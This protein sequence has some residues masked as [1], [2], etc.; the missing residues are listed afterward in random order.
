MKHF[1]AAISLTCLTI[2]S[3]LAQKSGNSIPLFFFRNPGL[4][5]S[6]ISFIVE[7]PQLRA[8]FRKDSVVFQL[9][10][11]NAAVRFFGAN[12]NVRIEAAEPQTGNVNF[13]IGD[14]SQWSAG[15]ATYRKITY[16]DLY[17]GI[18]M[19]YSG[20]RARVKS[21]FVVAPGADPSRIR[22]SY[23]AEHVSID[24]NGDLTLS[25]NTGELREAAP[26]I[27]QEI[28]GRRIYVDGR[29]LLLDAHTVG[30][31]I[32]A[33][34]RTKTLVIDPTLSYSTYLG[35]T[36]S[37]AVT[38]VAVDT[39]ANLYVTGW[40]AALN[41]PIAGSVQS[42][43]Q[44]GVD[45]F[46]VKLNPS[47]TSILYA[48]YI[49][50]NGDDRAAAI[51]VDAA[52]EA[53]VTGSTASTN[54][55]KVSSLR[56]TLGGGRDAYVLKLN[57]TGN[58]L[59][60]STLLGGMSN[61][62][63][64]AIAVDSS[65]NAYIAGDTLSTDFPINGPLQPSNGGLQDAFVTKLSSTGAMVFSTYLGG[66]QNEHAGGIAVDA[67]G[68][69]YV[70]GGTFSTNFPTKSPL[71]SANG[72]GQDAFVTKIAA[73][74]ASLVYSSYLGGT[75]GSVS[76]PEQANGIAIDSSGNAYVGGVTNSINFPVTSGA[77]QTAFRGGQD[78]FVTKINSAGSA[79]VYSTF[80]GGSS[81]DQVNGIA[82]DA[83]GNAYAAG[84]TSSQDF[85]TGSGVQAT[86]NGL[87]DAF[88]SELN[89]AGNGLAFSTY[90]GGTG[91]DEA[92]TIALDSLANIFV[93]GQTGS[94]DMTMKTPIQA[95]NTGGSTGW[96]ARI[97]VTSAPPQVPAVGTV[98]PSSGN[99]NTITFTATYSHPAGA[100][101]LTNVAFLVNTN[102]ST[103]YGCYIS[104]SPS[105]NQFM[106]YNDVAT[107][108]GTTV[109]PGG[110]TA[111]N[112]YCSLIGTGS[113]AT[114]SGTT[115]TITLSV[116]FQN[117][118]AGAKTIYLYAQDANTNTGWV[119]KG[120]Y[121]ATVAIAQPSNVSVS[122]NSNA[123]TTQTFQ[124]VWA[125]SQNPANL[126]ATAI[127][128]GASSSTLTNSCF[129]VYDSL[130]ATVQL[131]YDNLAGSNTKSISSSTPISNSQCSI[132]SASVQNSGLSIVLSLTISF[133]ATF[134]GQKN[135]FMY[136]SDAS[137][138][139]TG[140]QQMGTFTIAT[141]GYPTAD[142]VVPSSGTGP[143]Q[144]FTI[145]VSDVGGSAYINDI[146]V[147]IS[148]S[149]A[150]TN[151]ACF[152]LFDRV[153]NTLSVYYDNPGS[154]VT[155]LPLGSTGTASNSQCR[156]N[157]ANSTVIYGSTSVA[158]T[159]D[160]T[161]TSSF[162]G[163][164]NVYVYGAEASTNTGWAQRGTWTV[165]GGVPTAISVSPSAGTGSSLTNFVFA[166]SDSSS[167]S[168]L[169]G[170]SILVTSGA[171][172]NTANACYVVMNVT[173]GTVG[174][175]A[176]NGTT[177]NTKPFG[178]SANLLNSQ[179][180]I[181]GASVNVPSPGTTATFTVPILFYPAKFAGAK[182]VYLSANEPAATSGFVSVGS[183]TVQ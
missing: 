105:L 134:N 99:G 177:L 91:S 98:T 179:C 164:K 170:A 87:Y 44:G 144:R 77:F 65:G 140:W 34:D 157:A 1:L 54:F 2:G 83:S 175:Y 73:G 67:T 95:T 12:P 176:D 150:N 90:F 120:T 9:P 88:V 97:G 122:P 152:V 36:S 142:Y 22:L 121:T 48:T 15:N 37:G 102:A 168:N 35:G 70:A 33:Y 145:Q 81:F 139:S 8:G 136:A 165:T 57:S 72:G 7:T 40:T 112:D 113:S 143:A 153:R 74:G 53:Y 29:Y 174:L 20:D 38:A 169:S 137:G 13:L 126:T 110:G 92:M 108:G 117:E 61:D 103:N 11:M 161:F 26:E 60:W 178:S 16:R 62:W 14:R 23:I 39:A 45:S 115:L 158:L 107:S 183:W 124:F 50:G 41:F 68:N 106:I 160:L 4:A 43:N 58:T 128:F 123:G 46:V 181:G 133:T 84:Y 86:F 141:G 94:F 56:A 109:I 100:N 78:G 80:L 119:A 130:R 180:A 28:D 127:D 166:A 147:L 159:L 55:P 96:V 10:N 111:L 171:P 172:S 129:I 85:P 156:M 63:G 27:F 155:T 149:S 163:A 71:Q 154:G 47:G 42:S 118:F 114:L 66:S 173:A 18:D 151:G 148:T 138:A 116:I 5:N 76:L 32:G 59:L 131:Q 162:S 132:A 17:P 104:Y 167:G 82:V 101:A 125:D 24:S 182:T 30:F 93:G 64:N 135:I 19:N 79:T 21:E 89:A 49:G 3:G 52:G 146:A 6:E 25:S 31:E 69:V 75:G 51:A